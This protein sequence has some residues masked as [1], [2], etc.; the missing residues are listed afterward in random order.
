VS[1]PLNPAPLHILVALA[2]EDLHGY[3]IMQAIKRQSQGTYKL[4]PGTLYDNLKKLMDQGLVVDAPQ[5]ER[6]KNESRRLYRLTADGRAA[7]AAEILRLEGVIAH[8]RPHLKSRR[9]RKA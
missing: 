2:A 9:P 1:I 8:A 5:A 4:G 3:G 7:L 6:N